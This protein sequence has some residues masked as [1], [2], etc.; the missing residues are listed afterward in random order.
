MTAAEEF[1]SI[2][3]AN[4]SGTPKGICSVCSA[5]EG[6]IRAS[7]K[8]ALA[9]QSILL[10]ESTSNQ[11]DQFGGYTGMTPAAFANYVKN[12]A[13]ETGF[14]EHKL[15]LGGDHLGPNGWQN[16]KSEEAMQN[17]TEL[18]RSYVAAGFQ[19]IHLD[20]SML[21]ADDDR[22]QPL[23]D[24]TVARRAAQL[25]RI[26]E[27]TWK[28]HGT[29]PPVYVIGTEVPIPGGAQEHEEGVS[30]TPAS[31]ARRTVE[32]T[33]AAFK[34]LED[35]WERVCA[36]VVQPGVEFGDDQVFDFDA[37]KAAQLSR[38][39]DNIPNL[40]F[41]AHST[42]YQTPQA[43]ASMTEHHFCIQKVGP[44]LTFAW[45][46]ALFALACIEDELLPDETASGL[47]NLLDKVM[48]DDPK[49]WQK[50]YQGSGREIR[51]K[52]RYSY[53]DRSR[54]YWPDTKLNA[55]VKTLFANLVRVSIP[56]TL[57]SQFLP[58][59]YHAWRRGEVSLAPQELAEFHV[60]EVLKIYSSACRVS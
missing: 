54:Y 1:R 23:P 20:A 47:R 14:P 26:A 15:L 42:D 36:L 7:M 32:I 60:R 44:W 56:P 5:H 31:D 35:A 41:E 49:H 34:G 53:S 38:A 3:Q 40:V 25:C 57:L 30:V 43:L 9:D 18:I 19:K 11:V 55:A 13:S 51:I 45:R 28:A 22:S 59:Q 10:I 24:E 12:I 48:T 6:V 29:P 2:I 50:Y 4:K 46:E 16:L 58:I 27:E 21:L 17:S 52:R 39:L 33:K 37:A 8:Q